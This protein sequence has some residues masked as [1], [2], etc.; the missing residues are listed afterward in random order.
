MSEKKFT[1][2][3]LRAEGATGLA[4]DE[5]NFFRGWSTGGLWQHVIPF[6]AKIIRQSVLAATPDYFIS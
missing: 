1:I 4:C 3:G 5:R 6:I 2:S